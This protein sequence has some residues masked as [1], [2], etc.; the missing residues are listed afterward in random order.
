MIVSLSD[1]TPEY[2]RTR[3]PTTSI[4]A[5]DWSNHDATLIEQEEP[6]T[7]EHQGQSTTAE[8]ISSKTS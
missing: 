3:H 6:E 2:G 7:R 5:L 1:E 8:R 4:M